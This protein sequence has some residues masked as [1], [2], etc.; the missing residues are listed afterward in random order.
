MEPEAYIPVST[1]HSFRYLCLR[2]DHRPAPRLVR[3]LSFEICIPAGIL[4][5]IL[6]TAFWSQES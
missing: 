3:A 6:Q 1:I 2:R 5:K 4:N